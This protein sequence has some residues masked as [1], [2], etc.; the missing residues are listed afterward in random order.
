MNITRE[1]LKM[2]L[3]KELELACLNLGQSIKVNGKII[4]LM[5]KV[6]YSQEM[7]SS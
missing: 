5:D 2:D 1:I 4:I 6:F 7:E 3:N